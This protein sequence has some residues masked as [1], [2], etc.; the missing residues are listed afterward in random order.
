MKKP[1]YA[2]YVE[3]MVRGQL[4]KRLNLM[5]IGFSQLTNPL[6]VLL[7]IVFLFSRFR[8]LAG[9][10]RSEVLLCF[11][12][13]HLAFSLAEMSARGF[14]MFS[15]VLAQG[16]FDRVLVRPRGPMFQILASR[17][18][19]TRLGRGVVGAGVLGWALASLLPGWIQ[20]ATAGHGTRLVFRL[21]TLALM[22]IGGY[23][24][25]FGIFILGAAL[26]F[27]TTDSLEIVNILSDGGREMSQYP[28]TIYDKAFRR[29]FTF[30]I[31]FG[32]V[33]YLPLE[34]VL[35]R[36]AANPLV[37]LL[38]LAGFLFLFCC[39]WIWKA[40]ARRY[41]STGS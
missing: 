21:I 38:P 40:A 13:S 28:L 25:F 9:Y 2:R 29:F 34:F 5:L 15:Q 37:G 10:G 23:A 1:L 33:N 7:G 3:V 11:G 8:T 36:S 14:D 35:G 18:E 41:V 20:A 12:L 4:Q 16:E 31:P 22:G 26:A 39:A 32:C 27:L 30:V 24:I 17:L 19:L 6:T